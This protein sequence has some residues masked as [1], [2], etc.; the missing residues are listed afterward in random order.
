MADSAGEKSEKATSRKRRDERKQ[1]NVPQSKEVVIAATLVFTF[2][3]FKILYP[4]AQAA[5]LNAFRTYFD[6]VKSM[7]LLT[8]DDLDIMLIDG[9]KTLALA[10]LPLLLI[11]SVIA[12]IA[13][14]GQTRALFNFQS[15]KPKFSR[16]NPITGVKRLFSLKSAVELVKAIVKI[17]ILFVVIYNTLRDNI[18]LFPN[19]MDMSFAA[20]AGK[21]GGLCFHLVVNLSVVFAFIAL[22]DLLYQRWE[23]EKN[24][25]MTK[26]EV[27]QEYKNVEGDPKIKGKI[28][29]RQQA[30]SRRR[31]MQAVPTAD[32][33]IRNPTHY[34]VALKYE[35]GKNH[36]PIVVAKGAD[37]VAL[38]IIEIARA[39]R[40]ML[41][42]NPPLA[43]A[44]F[45]QIDL[46]HEIK[47]EFYQAVAEI[48][49]E[50]MKFKKA[51]ELKRG[52]D[53]LPPARPSV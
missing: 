46:E 13:T 36:A 17:A 38:K 29:Q 2:V 20:A 9:L 3:G 53:G 25:R 6:R 30:M 37:E 23:Y 14:F 42:E 52:S 7:N 12:V 27:K 31:M 48:I 28:K 47:E 10:A 21:I 35:P 39:N 40:V 1:G 8:S 45:A 4:T 26:E 22:L 18:T 15:L 19:M 49:A 43:R 44:L 50:L 33:V 5:M 24:I 34:A 16:M 41:V 51:H 11:T 32:V